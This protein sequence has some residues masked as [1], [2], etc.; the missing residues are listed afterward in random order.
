MTILVTGATGF[1]TAMLSLAVACTAVGVVAAWRL[2][3]FAGLNTKT[4][5]SG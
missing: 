5:T 3:R 1:S 2:T 4:S